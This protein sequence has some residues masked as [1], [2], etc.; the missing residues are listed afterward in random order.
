MERLDGLVVEVPLVA[1]YREIRHDVMR[2]KVSHDR[3]EQSLG[4][5]LQGM[6]M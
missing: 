2:A 3:I 4:S 6:K 5:V 1:M